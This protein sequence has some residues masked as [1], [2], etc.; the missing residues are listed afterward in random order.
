MATV[1]A[2]YNEGA[3]KSILAL[4][5]IDPSFAGNIA[6]LTAADFYP[7]NHQRIFAAMQSMYIAKQGIDLVTLSERMREMYGP[8]EPQLTK[9]LVDIVNEYHHESSWAAKSHIEI[10]KAA[11]LRRKMMEIL[12]GAK[13]ELSDETNDTAVVLDKTRQALRDIIVTGHS[14]QS[15]GDVLV[16]TYAA[17]ERRAKGEE[18]SMPSGISSI[19]RTT[20]G[21]HRGEVTIIGARPAVGKSALGAH[22]AMSTAA[23]GYKVAICSREMT[24]VQYGTR[25]ITRGS[26]IENTKLRTGDIGDDD[27][28]KIVEA[29]TL[30]GQLNLSF[31]FSTR[32]IEDLRMEVQKKVDAGELD[33][34]VI[35]Y[36]Q[37]MQ[38]KQRFDKDYL[39]IAY[40]SKMIKDMSVDLNISIISLAQVGRTSEG[41]MPTLAELRGSG[42]LEQ[43]ADNVIFMHKP[44]DA[45]D[46]FVRPSDREL[47]YTLQEAGMHYIALNIAKQRQGAVGA[48]PVV[49]DPAHMRFTAIDRS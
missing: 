1:T 34:L 45:N 5:V 10:I 46:K 19:D 33:M 3:E 29:L 32:Y 44:L 23:Q 25:I 42:D 48:V 43:D 40:I 49:F 41:S 39:R 26:D 14:W 47:F 7:E 28:D 17:L 21:F 20:T 4:M 16:S 22:I 13:A 38:T 18:P 30:Y 37:L 8:A 36:V 35:D 15:I 11:S 27:W 9:A 2:F 31:I 12:D 24:D 6:Q